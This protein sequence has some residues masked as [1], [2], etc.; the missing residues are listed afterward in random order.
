MMNVIYKFPIQN[1]Q[2]KRRTRCRLKCNVAIRLKRRIKLRRTCQIIDFSFFQRIFQ[3]NGK[4]PN[5]LE[6]WRILEKF[7][8]TCDD[9]IARTA[10]E[11]LW[12]HICITVG[13]LVSHV[14]FGDSWW[15]LMTFVS[16]CDVWRNCVIFGDILAI[17][18]LL[19]HF[20]MPLVDCVSVAHSYLEIHKSS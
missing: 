12:R 10:D 14:T 5:C 7:L 1:M 15:L 18:W 6:S 17:P 8:L 20:P 16:L 13:T 11:R 2:C 3:T 9:V 4:F 19:W